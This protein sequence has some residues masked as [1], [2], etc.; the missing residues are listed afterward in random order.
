M[1]I[2]GLTGGIGSGK[3]TVS[4]ALAR[5]GACIIDA[6]QIAR[7]V[8]EPGSSVL[9]ELAQAFGEDVVVDGVL[10]RSLLAS[11]AFVDE[12]HTQL[13][14]GITHPEIRRRIKDR[15]VQA[16]EEGN[17]VAVLDHPLLLEQGLAAEVDLVVVVDV[18][19]EIR[20]QRLVTFRGIEEQ[21]ARNRIARQ[22]S[23]AAR[24]EKA[25]V[26]IDNSCALSDLEPQIEE[27]WERLLKV[28]L[29]QENM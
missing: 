27:L 23:D 12:E 22:M 8:V 21:D 19:A 10:D 16:R 15:L 4:R 5:K 6:D 24:L 11:R 17:R 28:S 25:D 14:N 9:L 1:I 20:V 3:S 26:V 2:V 7:E 29:S 18:P 13:L